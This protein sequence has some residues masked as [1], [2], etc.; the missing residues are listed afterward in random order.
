M[1]KYLKGNSQIVEAFKFSHLK[2]DEFFEEFG[3]I[4]NTII[5]FPQRKKVLKFLS[6]LKNR[7]V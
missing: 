2:L 5:G 7:K 6:H 3:G 1:T 4:S